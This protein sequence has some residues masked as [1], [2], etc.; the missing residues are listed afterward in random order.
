MQFF[1]DHPT[2]N[3]GWLLLGDESRGQSAKRLN[4]SESTTLPNVP[5]VLSI[6]YVVPEP[7]S[8]MLLVVAMLFA[9][10]WKACRRGVS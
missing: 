3:F 5:P 2:D 9:P 1:L 10:A 4:S 7:S 6:S 8:V